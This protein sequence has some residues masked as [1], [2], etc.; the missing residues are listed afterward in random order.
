MTSNRQCIRKN[1]VKISGSIE[2]N[3][4]PQGVSDLRDKAAKMGLDPNIW[5]HSVEVAVAKKI[6]GK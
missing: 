4:G 6:G 2:I 5:F 1:D 3:A